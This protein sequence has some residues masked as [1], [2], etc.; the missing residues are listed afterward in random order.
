MSRARVATPL[1]PAQ[2]H[3]AIATTI[4]YQPGSMTL[5]KG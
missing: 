1:A 5:Q 4:Y 2:P 3:R